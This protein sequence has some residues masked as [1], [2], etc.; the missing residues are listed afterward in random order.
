MMAPNKMF[1]QKHSFPIEEVKRLLNAAEHDL[2]IAEKDPFPE[3]KFTFAYNALIKGGIA[4]LAAQGLRLRSIPGHHAKL[5]EKLADFL[6]DSD[7]CVFGN[8]MRTKRNMDMYAGSTVISEKE[9]NDYLY[10]VEATISRVRD[11]CMPTPA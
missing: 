6:Q 5:I 4:L 8:A 11:I 7:V 9:A 3:V 1:F 2:A 10:F